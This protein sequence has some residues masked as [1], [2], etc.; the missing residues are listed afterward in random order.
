MRRHASLARRKV[1][2]LTP[3][4]DVF[5]GE[6]GSWYGESTMPGIAS[7]IICFGVDSAP[8]QIDKL[9]ALTTLIVSVLPCQWAAATALSRMTTAV[10]PTLAYQLV[11]DSWINSSVVSMGRSYD[12]QMNV[13]WNGNGHT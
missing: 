10:R 1:E 6:G 12:G 7:K 3:L 8:G 9:S 5:T 11:Y 2:E 4:K 13:C